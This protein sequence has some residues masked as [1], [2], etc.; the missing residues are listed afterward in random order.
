MRMT[1][2]TE[3]RAAKLKARVSVQ[4][5][6][7]WRGS[8]GD[9][10]TYLGIVAGATEEE[11]HRK[12]RELQERTGEPGLLNLELIQDEVVYI[13]RSLDGRPLAAFTG[14]EDEAHGR[15]E[16]FILTQGILASYEVLDSALDLPSEE[17]VC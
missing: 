10:V 16:R 2:A 1:T 5:E 6:E 15:A 8:P 11:L 7:F 13:V 12:A 3:T 4:L 9:R 14:D 17:V